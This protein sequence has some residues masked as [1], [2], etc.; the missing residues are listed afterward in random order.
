LS[1]RIL[2]QALPWRQEK[3]AARYSFLNANTRTFIYGAL[4]ATIFFILGFE[5]CRTFM[6][7]TLQ[8][9]QE[10]KTQQCRKWPVPKILK[11]YVNMQAYFPAFPHYRKGLSDKKTNKA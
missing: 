9:Q 6:S 10:I 5:S 3:Q 4:F 7:R 1:I 8:L 11:A 2:F